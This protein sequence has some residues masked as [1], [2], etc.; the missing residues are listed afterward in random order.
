ELVRADRYAGKREKAVAI[1]DDLAFEPGVGLGRTDARPREN[2]AACI[3]DR[4]GDLRCGLCESR[5][6]S[7]C[8]EDTTP[9]RAEDVRHSFSPRRRVRV[10]ANCICEVQ[11]KKLKTPSAR[12]PPPARSDHEEPGGH[13]EKKAKG[14]SGH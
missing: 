4:A 2:S 5:R 6:R 11:A 3:F 10:C 9:Q 1:R 8:D 12:V 7:Q 13:E 14:S